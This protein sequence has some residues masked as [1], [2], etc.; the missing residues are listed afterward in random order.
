MRLS[1][2][3]YCTT[4]QK[5]RVLRLLLVVSL[6]APPPPPLRWYGLSPIVLAA[7]PTLMPRRMTG[8][9]IRCGYIMA[10]GQ[11]LLGYAAGVCPAWMVLGAAVLG[12]GFHVRLERRLTWREDDASRSSG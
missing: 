2:E 4:V 8:W 7:G 3:V 6:P 12:A 10:L 9:S 1:G 11:L 5:D